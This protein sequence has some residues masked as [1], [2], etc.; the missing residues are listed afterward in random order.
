MLGHYFRNL[1]HIVKYIDDDK[2]L[3]TFELKY[4]Y[5]KILGA[6][7]SALEINLISLKGLTYHEIAPYYPSYFKRKSNFL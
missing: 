5:V 6:Q 1:Y 4:K 2:S 7:L 3:K